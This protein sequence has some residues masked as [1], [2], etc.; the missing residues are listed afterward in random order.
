MEVQKFQIHGAQAKE[1]AHAISSDWLDNKSQSEDKFC[2]TLGTSSAL[3]IVEKYYLRIWKRVTGCFFFSDSGDHVCEALITV[4][5][6]IIPPYNS[7]FGAEASYLNA[8]TTALEDV[9]ETRGWRAERM[10][11]ES[12]PPSKQL[13]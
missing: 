6:G 4:S 12:S 13:D 3:F 7:S 8:L 2:V 1:L 5:G 11:T 9:C 10:D